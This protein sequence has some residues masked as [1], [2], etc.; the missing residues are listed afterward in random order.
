MSHTE[1]LSQTP[2]TLIQMTLDRSLTVLHGLYNKT[3]SKNQTDVNGT[4]M[5]KNYS[6]DQKLLK[7]NRREKN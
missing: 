7:R 1:C 6:L 2:K 4:R 3:H 5:R